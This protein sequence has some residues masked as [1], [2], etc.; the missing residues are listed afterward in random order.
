MDAPVYTFSRNRAFV[1]AL[2]AADGRFI[3]VGSLALSRY[4][5]DRAVRDLDVLIEP[6]L[7][8]A[9]KV[10]NALDSPLF[11]VTFAA[12]DLLRPVRLQIPIKIDYHMDILTP[13]P[14]L[15]FAAEY[16]HAQGARLGSVV[17]KFAAPSTLRTLLQRSDDP[18]HVHD[19][20]AL[21]RYEG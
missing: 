6:T 13:G 16:Q 1:E 21:D 12:E 3:I 4:V 8:N 7:E 20:L 11:R 10:V 19:L 17:V 14:D 9:R 18:K 15:D 2:A 5:P